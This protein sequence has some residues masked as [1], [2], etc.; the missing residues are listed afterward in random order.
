VGCTFVVVDNYSIVSL[1]RYV[2][3]N[4]NLKGSVLFLGES[5]LHAKR[6]LNEYISRYRALMKVFF[7]KASHGGSIRVYCRF[8]LVLLFVCLVRLDSFVLSLLGFHSLAMV[9]SRNL[10]VFLQWFIKV[11]SQF[12]LE[13]APK[14]LSP[15]RLGYNIYLL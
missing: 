6:K 8:L 10:F 13:G 5:V 2:V 7:S 4:V 14:R 15:L 12:R 1:F 11:L 9:F 3:L